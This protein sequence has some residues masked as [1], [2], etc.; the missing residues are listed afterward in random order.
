[1]VTQYEVYSAVYSGNGIQVTIVGAIE[2]TLYLHL[3]TLSACSKSKRELKRMLVFL[4]Q[5]RLNISDLV[6][7]ETI[8]VDLK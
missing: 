7:L 4:E 6:Y 5:S 2:T 8:V 1:M 3:F